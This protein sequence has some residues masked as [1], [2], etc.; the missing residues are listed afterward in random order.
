MTEVLITSSVLIAVIALLR[1]ILRD[2]IRP[3]LQFALWGLV[4]LRLLVP[5]SWFESPV[6]VANAAEPVVRQVQQYS[7]ENTRTVTFP[8]TMGEIPETGA[9]TE[10]AA[11]TVIAPLDIARWVW[12]GGAAVL[13]AW[14]LFVNVRLAWKLSRE[15]KLY[16]KT[17][18]IPVYV[19][20]TLPS[21]CLYL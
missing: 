6:S 3:G 8:V 19:T 11:P 4:L 12:L 17:H 1:A 7:A 16:S 21:P 13:A 14:F 15:R 18:K 20:K 9:L 5:V 10:A 2:R